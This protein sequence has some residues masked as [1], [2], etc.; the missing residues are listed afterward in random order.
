MA[1]PRRS[2]ATGNPEGSRHDGLIFASRTGLILA[3]ASETEIPET[4]P[5]AF[6]PDFFRNKGKT[7]QW[8]AFVSDLS[9][10]SPTLETVV[11][12]LATFICCATIRVRKRVNQDEK[13]LVGRF[14]RFLSSI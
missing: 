5:D 2:P 13:I 4:I 8:S 6:T 9:A 1:G 12:E 14:S 11:S 10:E 3:S 7:Q